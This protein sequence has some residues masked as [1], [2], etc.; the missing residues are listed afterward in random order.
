MN[1]NQLQRWGCGVHAGVLRAKSFDGL[2]LDGRDT[3][4]VVEVGE[5]GLELCELGIQV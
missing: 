3:D 1:L 4:M 5:M 2:G